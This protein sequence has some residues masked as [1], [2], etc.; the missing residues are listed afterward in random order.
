MAKKV[1]MSP[2][3]ISQVISNCITYLQVVLP[4][5]EHRVMKAHYAWEANYQRAVD[6][7]KTHDR[8]PR[9]RGPEGNMNEWYRTQRARYRKGFLTLEQQEKVRG[10][11]FFNP[12]DYPHLR[13]P[14]TPIT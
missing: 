12:N 13:E 7:E 4:T 5:G 14:V 3:R 11:K 10:L 2:S 6:F 9:A 8:K 1:D